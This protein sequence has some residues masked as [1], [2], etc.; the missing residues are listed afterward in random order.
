MLFRRPASFEV[1]ARL[2]CGEATLGEVY[3]FISG[4]YFR[5]K[6]VYATAFA[7]GIT[8]TMVIVP[9]AGLVPLET[10]M[11]L[12]QIR[13]FGGVSIERDYDTYRAALLR[14]ARLLEQAVAPTCSFILLGSIA[15][16]KYSAPL[17][18]VF[19]ERLMF[20]SE[21]V[22]RGDMSRGGLMLRAAR[23][24]VELEYSPVAGAVLRGARPP[25]LCPLTRK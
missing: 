16:S 12:E 19:G 18:E 21:F 7:A 15:T 3:S 5:G 23:A 14:D 10:R 17:L 2:H 1:A 6:V 13:T 11:T 24:G 4:L 20:P 22:G 25:K 9:G 8:P